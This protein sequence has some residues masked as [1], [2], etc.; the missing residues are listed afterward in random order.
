MGMTPEG[1]NFL[2]ANL[3]RT[4]DKRGRTGKKV[5]GDT[6]QEG[7]GWH[8]S[9][10]NKNDSDEQKKKK[11]VSFSG[12]GWHRRTGRRWSLKKVA[13][14]FHGKTGATPSVAAPSDTNPSDATATNL[15]IYRRQT[16]LQGRGLR[17]NARWSS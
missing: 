13:S 1:E 9:E 11:V 16:V 3:Q 7:G 5:R 2:W 4:A 15:T 8:P 12:E 14:F 10:I 6:L 17:G